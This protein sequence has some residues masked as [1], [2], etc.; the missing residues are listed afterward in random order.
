M[1]LL[2]SL[3]FFAVLAFGAALS[4]EGQLSGS[5]AVAQILGKWHCSGGMAGSFSDQ[6]YS[7]GPGGVWFF[8]IV[9]GGPL[10]TFIRGGGQY[11]AAAGPNS[12]DIQLYPVDWRPTQICSGPYGQGGNCT[13]VMLH[14]TTAHWQFVG[15]NTVRSAQGPVCQRVQ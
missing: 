4:A 6:E 8:V 12:L 15:P 5:E 10:G 3:V 7:F 13:K 2:L 1:R 9:W 11:T 14:Q